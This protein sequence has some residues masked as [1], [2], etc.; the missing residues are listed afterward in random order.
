MQPAAQATE[1]THS[2]KATRCLT[3]ARP[4]TQRRRSALAAVGSV[5]VPGRRVGGPKRAQNC[6][7][8]LGAG[9]WPGGGRLPELPAT[10]SQLH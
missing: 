8:A 7:G 4:Q 2:W 5:G 3:A 1:G 10:L 6:R 9:R